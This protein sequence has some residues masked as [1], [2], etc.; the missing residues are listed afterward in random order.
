MRKS[1]VRTGLT[2]AELLVALVVTS[3][4]LSAVATLAFAMSSATRAA[5]DT[6]Y[7]QTEVRTTALRLVELIRN[8]CM[9]CAAPAGDLVIWKSDD[10]ANGV[11][12]VN[13]LAYIE[14]D[15]SRHSVCLWLF[16]THDNPSVLTALGLSAGTPVL[17]TLALANT[18]A[19]LVSR[20]QSSG[21]VNHLVILQNCRNVRFSVD[22]APPRTRRVTISFDLTESTGVHHYEVQASLL[23][24][25][26]H[27][28]NAG[29]TDLV[30][31]DD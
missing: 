27:L 1:K 26:E 22:Q 15:D 30:T 13:E 14:N 21:E 9:V 12:D 18:K 19:N 5:E 17:S 24:S 10:N 31:D 16:N 6:A 8:C 2:I 4:I 11:I 28:L 3:I 7:T 25:A 29:A 20:Y 23:G